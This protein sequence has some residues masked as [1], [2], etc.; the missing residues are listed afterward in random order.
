MNTPSLPTKPEVAGI[1]DRAS[2]ITVSAPARY[3]D[4][5]PKPLYVS[6][7]DTEPVGPAIADTTANAAINCTT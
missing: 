1:P 4:R 2:N 3:G 7:G 5:L 6:S